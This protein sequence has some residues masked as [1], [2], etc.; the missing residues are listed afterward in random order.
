MYKVIDCIRNAYQK[1]IAKEMFSIVLLCPRIYDP[2]KKT[3]RRPRSD[4]TRKAI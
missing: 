2:P 3:L 4:A 1:S